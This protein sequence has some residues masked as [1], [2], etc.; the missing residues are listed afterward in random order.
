MTCSSAFSFCGTTSEIDNICSCQR[1][2]INMSNLPIK[3]NSFDGAPGGAA[4]ALT[5]QA[6]YGTPASPDVS[7]N[8]GAFDSNHRNTAADQPQKGNLKKDLDQ[9]YAN[10]RT[11]PTPD[12]VITGIKYEMGQQIKKDKASA[13]QIVIAHLKKDPKFYS[14]LKHLNITDKDMMDNMTE[15]T[16]PNTGIDTQ[17]YLKLQELKKF[18]TTDYIGLR[19]MREQLTNSLV[20][21]ANSGKIFFDGTTATFKPLNESRHPNDSAERPKV[22]PNIEETKKIFADM[23]RGHDKKYVVNSGICDVM[24][25]MWKAKNA[26]SAWRTGQ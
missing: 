25:E 24:K 11:A 15:N 12:E 19:L 3:E 13:K 14:S 5:Y 22:T 8:P 26:R 18:K 23:A 17:V 6:P 4:G 16:H 10:P 21:L 1:I 9:L 2:F 7:Q 20:R